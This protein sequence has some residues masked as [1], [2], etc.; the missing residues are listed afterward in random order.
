MR[1]V[2]LAALA[3]GLAAPAG[4]APDLRRTVSEFLNAYAAGDKATVIATVEPDVQLY[5]SDLS[6]VYRGAEGA[7]DML[8]ADSKL[9]GGTAK[10][11]T[12]WHVSTVREGNLGAIMFDVPFTAGK[13]AQVTLRFAMVWHLEAGLWKLVQSSNTVPTTGQGAPA[14]K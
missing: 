4:A 12:M 14:D 2:L 5:G 3:A 7:S 6:E 1:V 11:G 13:A 9:W 8:D 10:F